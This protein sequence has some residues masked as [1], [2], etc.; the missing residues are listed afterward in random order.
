[1]TNSLFGS[2]YFQGRK[3]VDAEKIKSIEE[4]PTPRNVA[5]VRSCIGL[6]GY[7]IRFIEGL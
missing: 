3:V 6:V 1:V 7:Y 2:Y 4:L 5:K